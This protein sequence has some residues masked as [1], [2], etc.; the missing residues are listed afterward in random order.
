MIFNYKQWSVILFLISFTA[1]ASALI[2]EY[3]FNLTPC[4]MCLKQRH[5]YYA[6]IVLLI[7]FYFFKKNNSFWLLFLIEACILYGLFYSVWHVGIEQG[8][9]KGPASCSEMLMQTDSVEELKKQIT[10]KP[11]VSCSEVI[12]AIGGISAATLNTILLVFICIFN[13]M[14][15]I[16]YFNAIKN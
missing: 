9:L 7:I 12:W 10:N 13:T 5:P 6:L 11:V 14:F 15:I 2:A 4:E 3:L 16:R 1:L 8:L